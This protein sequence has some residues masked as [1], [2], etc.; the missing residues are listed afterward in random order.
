M[1]LVLFCMSD[2]QRRT[3][4]TLVAQEILAVEFQVSLGII[5]KSEATA[6]NRN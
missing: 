3:L 4:P 6:E 5:E 2:R 1:C